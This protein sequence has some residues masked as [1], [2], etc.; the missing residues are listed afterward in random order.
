MDLFVRQFGGW[1]RSRAQKKILGAARSQ[2]FDAPYP[3]SFLQRWDVFSCQPVQTGRDGDILE[4]LHGIEAVRSRRRDNGEHSVT[5]APRSGGHV[6][7]ALLGEQEHGVPC[8][9]SHHGGLGGRDVDWAGAA[10]AA[11]GWQGLRRALHARVTAVGRRLNGAA[12]P[13]GPPSPWRCPGCTS[14]GGGWGENA[15]GVAFTPPTALRRP[16]LHGNALAA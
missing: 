2:V 10:E 14:D 11:I 3:C 16:Q 13:L 6:Q 9:R 7:D 8:R 4:H 12:S 1:K 15:E 5:R